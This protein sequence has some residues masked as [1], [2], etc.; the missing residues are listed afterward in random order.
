MKARKRKDLVLVTSKDKEFGYSVQCKDSSH[1]FKKS[2]PYRVE[3]ATLS[4]RIEII[5]IQLHL[6]RLIKSTVLVS[7][8]IDCCDLNTNEDTIN[9]YSVNNALG[10]SHRCFPVSVLRQFVGDIHGLYTFIN[11]FTKAQHYTKTPSPLQQCPQNC[12]AHLHQ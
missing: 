11:I 9:L 12:I 6:H 7:D 1:H 8:P 5:C 4:K 2:S 3:Q 10:I